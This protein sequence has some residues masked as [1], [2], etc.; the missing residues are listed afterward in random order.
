MAN[1]AAF[2]YLIAGVLF[3]MSLRGLSHPTTSRKGNQYGMI[4]MAIAVVTTLIVF[5]PDG[6]WGWALIMVAIGIGG[7]AGGT[8][9]KRVEMTKMPQL[10]AF[11]HSLVGLAAVFVVV[12]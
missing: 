10:V 6:F 3:I 9:A 12:G 11:F 7:F 1:F 4:G 8:I 2:A 5:P